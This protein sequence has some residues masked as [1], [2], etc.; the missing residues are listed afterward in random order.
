MPCFVKPYPAGG[1]NG[2][3]TTF[4]AN[5]EAA[6]KSVERLFGVVQGRW[7][8]IR[9]GNKI[10]HHDKVFIIK[11]IELCFMMHNLIVIRKGGTLS[12]SGFDG[13]GRPHFPTLVAHLDD[14]IAEFEIERADESKLDTDA[15]TPELE[16]VQSRLLRKM[17]KNVKEL[18]NSDAYFK[19]R[20][21]LSDSFAG[22]GGQ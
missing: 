21:A 14:G 5:Q 18:Y 2:R 12:P 4:N 13:Q 10:D 6:R 16:R 20:K 8:I 11:I 7:K 17:Q 1:V 3:E 19:L 22:G 9:H 15:V